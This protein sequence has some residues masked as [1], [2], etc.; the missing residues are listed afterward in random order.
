[1]KK[2]LSVIMV[3]AMLFTGI[4]P[5]VVGTAAA[6]AD[7]AEFVLETAGIV[8]NEETGVG[9]AELTL[10]LTNGAGVQGYTVYVY[11]QNADVSIVDA[12]YD[13]DDYPVGTTPEFTY[14]TPGLK[15]TGRN[16][17]ANFTAAG[18]EPSSAIDFAMVEC[19]YEYEE[20]AEGPVCTLVLETA[21]LYEDLPEGYSFEVGVIIVEA[22]DVDDADV[23]VCDNFTI[24]V[25]SAAGDP[26]APVYEAETF[27]A[28]QFTINVTGTNVY[29]G[30]VDENG[31]L[32]AP[33]NIEFYGNNADNNVKGVWATRV[34]L[35]YPQDIELVALEN[36]KIYEDHNLTPGMFN[37]NIFDPKVTNSQGVPQ[38]NSAA[39]KAFEVCGVDYETLDPN[40]TGMFFMPDDYKA[41]VFGDGVL[42]TATFKLPADAQIG[43]EWYVGI[44]NDTAD[45]SDTDNNDVAFVLDNG[46]IKIV[47]KLPA[48]EEETFPADQFTI[49][50]QGVTVAEGTEEISLDIE[51]Y[52][53][54]ADNNV[55][56]V[57]ATRVFVYYPQDIELIALE[58]GKIYEDHNLTPGMF[59]D[60]IFDPKVTNSQGVPQANSAA[61]KAF[62]VCGVDYETLDPNFTGMFF[63]PD[64]YKAQVFGDGCLATVTFKLPADA[65]AGTEWYVG[66]VNDTADVSD[67]DNNDVAFVL[68]NGYIKVYGA[69]VCDHAE[70][71]I[72][73]AF[74]A[75]CTEPG[76]SG[77]E[78]CAACGE[79]IV[80]G[81]EIA[82]LGHTAGDKVTVVEPTYTTEGSYEIRCSVCKELLEEGIIP[83]LVKPE[84]AVGT[85]DG[86]IGSEVKVPVTIENNGGLFIASFTVNYDAALTYAGFEIGDVFAADNVYV[87]ETGDGELVLYFEALDVADVTANGTLLNLVFAIDEEAAEGTAAISIVANADDCINAAGESVDIGVADGAVEMVY[88]QSVIV[89]DVEVEYKKDATVPVVIASNPGVWAIRAE[90]ALGD[91]TVKGFNDGLFAL[92][93]GE[94]YSIADGVLTVFL[95]GAALE[96]IA[97]NAALFEIIFDLNGAAEGTTADIDI[98]LVEVIDVDGNDLDFVAKSGTITVVPCAHANV[99]AT[100]TK[101]PSVYEDGVLSYICDNCG[102]TVKTEAIPALAGIEIPEWI[103]ATAKSGEYSFEVNVLNNP[104]VWALSVEIA[105]DAN[106]IEI[107]KLLPG[108]FSVDEFSYSVADG[109]LTVYVESDD[110]AN[111]ADDGAAFFVCF[112]AKTCGYTDLD[113]TL[114]A[115]N[116]INADGENVAF[117]CVDG[118]VLAACALTYV[119]AVEPGCHQNGSQEYWYCEDCNAVYADADGRWLTNIRN[120]TIPMTAELIYVEAVE[121][122]CHQNGMAAYYY[123][124]E[125]DAVFDEDMVLTNRKNLTIP[126]TAEIIHVEAAEAVC[127]QNGNIEYWYC[128][129]CDAVFADAALTQLTNF[130]NVIIPAP[131]ALTHVDAVEGSCHQTGVAEYW[132]CEECEAVFADAAG[133]ILTNRKNLVIPAT[134]DIMHV[135]AVEANCHQTGNVEYWFCTECMAVFTDGALTQL[136]NFKSVIIPAETDLTYV[137][138][139]EATCHQNGVAEYWYCEICDAIFSDAAGRYITN[140]K[141]LTIPYTAEIVHVDAVE[142]TCCQ[143]GNIE[144]WYCA[145]CQAVFTDAALTQLSNFM[146]VKTPA[147]AEIIYV[148]AVEP[149]CCQNGSA[150]Y[151]YCSEC[152][153]VYDEDF[154]LTNRKNLTI[155]AT[156]EIIY[157][158]AVEPTCCQNGS[159]A[160]YYCSECD[161]VYD[162]DFRLTNRKN[163]TIPAT[164][165]IIYVEAV[166]PTCCQNGSAAYYYCSECDAVYDEDFRLT[167][168]KNLTIPATA[169]LIYVE[170]VE[171]TCCQN[172]SAA[173][174]YCSECDAVFDEDMVLTNRK[175]LTI[176]ATAELIYVEAVEPTCC[177]NG[178]AAYYYCSECDAV[179]DEDMVLTNRKNLT[180]PATAEII[181]VEAVEPTC[182]QNGSAAYYYCSE[183]DAVFDE[184]MVLTNRKNLTIPA[185]GELVYVE[186]VE[187]T[188]CQNGS[189]AYYY[190]TTCDAVFDEDMVLTNRKNLT[191]PATAEIIYVEAVE[192]TCH[193]NGS[194]AYYYCSECDA[195][196]DEDFIL[197][198]RKN[199]TIPYTAEIVHVEA[200]EANCHQ[201][202]NVEYWYC[203]DCLAVFT[204]AALTQL[205]NFKNVIIP[206]N[207]E[208]VHVAKVAATCGANGCAEYWYCPECDAVFA[209]AAGT[210]LTNR[211]NLTIPATGKHFRG[212]RANEIKATAYEAGSYDVKCKYCDYIFETVTVPT[213]DLI[214]TVKPYEGTSSVTLDGTNISVVAKD[215][216]GSVTFAY[217]CGAGLT[218]TA[219]NAT[220]EPGGG[221]GYVTVPY[222][223]ENVT[224]TFTKNSLEY[225]ISETYTVNV[226]FNDVF[227]NDYHAGY[228][229]EEIVVDG[230]TY[231]VYAKDGFNNASIGFKFA[232]GCTYEAVGYDVENVVPNGGY[233]YFKAIAS[234][235]GNE[236]TIKV[237]N[238][239]GV[240]ETY[241]IK[242]VF[243]SHLEVKNVI[244]GYMVKSVEFVEGANVINV[245]S[246]AKV[247]YA[248]INYSLV[249][250]KSDIV[251]DEDAVTL[252]QANPNG[253]KYFKILNTGDAVTTEMTISNPNTG[254]S[255]VYVI[256]VIFE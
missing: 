190:C 75:T 239:N 211:L 217:I 42:A 121:A 8:E 252:Y 147:T 215:N 195:V 154:R 141:N 85:V 192:A 176:P 26:W 253:I 180:I 52:G 207:N 199:L 204:D 178:S 240:T 118:S 70:T 30:T 159:A 53:N 216:V 228:S 67:T 45:V 131:V 171:P 107:T 232:A 122:A 25:E 226:T 225:A 234:A 212:V 182:C 22:Y 50:M 49:N 63:M 43:D 64:D 184:D 38:A 233:V 158:E 56:G 59:N 101:A 123:C 220:V 256:N 133:T 54:N 105:Y 41:Q 205:T 177:Q 198:N 112:E 138:A 194:A 14:V 161:S 44:V 110:L 36:G 166:E 4:V 172:G 10:S 78:V 125:C 115:E 139:V 12:V 46:Y 227:V 197:T 156:A 202:G 83:V 94:N 170:A 69:N 84:V 74:D 245:V 47:P 2:I 148:E 249:N 91:L 210:I 92:V 145:D 230:T 37:D 15:S 80:P 188:C 116:T 55:K 165:E 106:I 143:T 209:D 255:E 183:C 229:A 193:Q 222:G 86:T 119:E 82:A 40:F 98:K 175:N 73:G 146:S 111:V 93:E 97:D 237:T 169:E 136:S 155:P 65:K 72:D 28:D 201:T 185:T 66:I 153:S 120:L 174:Y 150:A 33:V 241:T 179:F 254:V 20:L 108:T 213:I 163:L 61:I 79:I 13:E 152:D 19:G 126:Y 88:P 27:P 243:D 34:F 214:T 58:N 32:L 135:A 132:Y 246:N 127:H 109:V 29:E 149:T 224:L 90:I 113:A 218:V 11:Y 244:G 31:D 89:E 186:A 24:A 251:Y 124:S 128:S 17:K 7:V 6:D 99:T 242:Y 142:P 248:T 23:A 35:Y 102:E 167:N 76:F 117:E 191:I 57:W 196:F 87:T 250:S 114:V 162:E 62:E 3:V 168:R 103:S 157:V 81:T 223:A 203:A 130:K 206:A 144:Y 235:N 221:Y 21:A 187:P 236:Y 151:Y 160:Y 189:A 164:A 39:I 71:I 238:A 208:L 100:E 231:T 134:A 9:T 16:Y 247:G 181:Y 104:G 5:S 219:E 60:N 68:D 77:N 1:M 129:E 95:E 96:N 173:Y 200:V 137:P 48:Y 51:F 140:Y 18:I